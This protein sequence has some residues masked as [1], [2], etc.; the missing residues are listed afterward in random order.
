MGQA[1][2]LIK[3]KLQS[4]LTSIL[5][6]TIIILA[7]FKPSVFAQG[8]QNQGWIFLTHTQKF[9][10]KLDILFDAQ[11]RTADQYRY[12]NTLLLRTAL[13]YNINDSHSIAVGLAYK[14]DREKA[15]DAYEYTNERRIFQQYSYISKIMKIEM[16][17]RGRLEQRWIKE[18][19]VSFSQRGRIFIS[20]Q[21]PLFA[22]ADFSKGMYAAIQ[23]EVFFNITNKSDV[24]NSI[25]DQN[26]SFLSLG[27][28]W[29]KAVDTEIGYMYWYQKEMDAIVHRNIIQLQI[30]TNF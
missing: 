18:E 26:R 28:R 21:I 11:A 6:A 25:F 24:N 2:L 7:F 1:V 14:A 17:I 3:V 16:T 29:N 10:Q 19:T 23:D 5:F 30:T 8:T 4:K 15:L 20:A 27:Y 12:A 13:R 9:T 22:N